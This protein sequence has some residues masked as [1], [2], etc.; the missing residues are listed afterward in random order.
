MI[1]EFFLTGAIVLQITAAVLAFRLTRITGRLSAWIL[2][3]IALALMSVRRMIPLARALFL[4]GSSTIDPYNEF[5]GL[6]LSGFMAV[7]IAMIGPIFK[8]IFRAEREL[9]ESEQ[10]FRGFFELS[11]VGVAIASADKRLATVNDRLCG[12]LGYSKLELSAMTINELTYP[13]DREKEL[14]LDKS[15]EEGGSDSYVLDKRFV[16]KDGKLMWTSEAVRCVRDKDGS[17]S[18]ALMVAQDISERKKDEEIICRSLREKETLLRELYH[19]TKN[20]MQ[21]ICALLNLE[22]V[23][24]GDKRLTELFNLIENRIF[25]MSL[26]HE[27]L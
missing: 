13:E 9:K 19:R 4:N 26:V 15:V 18:Y 23:Q 27:K 24:C 25:S 3:S 10:R 1:S 14:L 5:I 20:N 12:M 7:G 16:R 6:L 8:K 22:S 21:M 17:V 2:I 11:L